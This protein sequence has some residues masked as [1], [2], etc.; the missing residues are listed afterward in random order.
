MNSS[1][2]RFNF[3]ILCFGLLMLTVMAGCVHVETTCP[4]CCGGKDGGN[5]GACNPMSYTG[6]ATNFWD[7]ARGALYTGSRNCAA[8]S[9]KCA[10][11][12]GRCND[13]SV[14]KSR[15]NSNT[16]VCKCDCKP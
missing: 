6:P 5:D 7:D 15:V 8:G 14:C 11:P 12:A 2:R 13:G 1:F 9:K 4:S 3:Q 10:I 16:M